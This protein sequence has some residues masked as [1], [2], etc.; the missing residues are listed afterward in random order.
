MKFFKMFLH[1]ILYLVYIQ[2]NI[3]IWIFS[4]IYLLDIKILILN[5]MKNSMY[6]LHVHAVAII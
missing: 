1:D 3:F 4:K 6:N 2:N 5:S